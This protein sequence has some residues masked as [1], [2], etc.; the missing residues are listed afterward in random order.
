MIFKTFLLEEK[1]LLL[2]YG[3][4]KS[5]FLLNFQIIDGFEDPSMKIDGF[6][7]TYADG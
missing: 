3:N 4:T 5:G 6:G 2:T 7:R 1:C